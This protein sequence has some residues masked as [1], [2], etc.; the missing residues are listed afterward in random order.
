MPTTRST[1]VGFAAASVLALG[2]CSSDSKSSP[3]SAA[4]AASAMSGSL[5]AADQSGD[6]QTMTIKAVNIAGSAGFI[7]VH[8]DLDGKPGP[9]V[10]HVAI[11]A[12]DSSDVV[13]TL[14]KATPTGAYWPMLHLDAGTI[15]TYEF[16]GPDVPVKSGADIVMKKITVTVP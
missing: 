5:D 4:P 3:A 14:D 6:G 10:G 11:P 1:I 13:V 9:V 8:A 16:P 7:A 12:G 15:G 2:A